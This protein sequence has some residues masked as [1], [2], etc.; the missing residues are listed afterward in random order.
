M[1]RPELLERTR[2]ESNLPVEDFMV[3]LLRRCVTEVLRTLPSAIRGFKVLDVGCGGQ[4]FREAIE[5]RGLTYVS[6]DAQDPR[7]IVDCVAEI[8][9][10]LPRD[11]FTRG[12]FDFILCT[13]LLEHVADWDAAFR[14]LSALLKGGGRLLVT[15]P[16][17]YILHEEPYDFWRPT[18]HALREYAVKHGLKV[19]SLEAAGGAWDVLGT[20]L[21]ANLRSARAIRPSFTNRLLAGAIDGCVGLLHVLLKTGALQRRISWGNPTYPVYLSNVGVFSKT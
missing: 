16:Q 8:D 9:G 4:P 12:P 15:C 11:V 20:L 3:P 10:E 2:Y 19:V 1:T 5:G 7:G 14:N 13:E 18:I 21:G 17:F 6:M